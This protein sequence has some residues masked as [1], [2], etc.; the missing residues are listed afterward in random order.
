MFQ[1]AVRERAALLTSNLVLA[2][3]QRFVLFHA[4]P[5]AAAFV[6]DR[7]AASARTELVF[8]TAAHHERARTWLAR[9]TDQRISYTDAVSFALMED[10]KCAAVMTFDADFSTAGFARWS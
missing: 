5:R 9:L 3:V 8:A 6:L 1:R 4:G 10:R 2:E 7:V